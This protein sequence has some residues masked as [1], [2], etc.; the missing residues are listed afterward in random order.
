MF[1]KQSKITAKLDPV[2]DKLLDGMDSYGPESEEYAAMLGYLER[3]NALTSKDKGRIDPNQVLAAAANILGILTIVAYEQRH[4]F[5]S[6]GFE[7]V[8][9][10]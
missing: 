4:I 5:T 1:G 8:K 10:R 6:K 2:V 9:K 3:V 7:L